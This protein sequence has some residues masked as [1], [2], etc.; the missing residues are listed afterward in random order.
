VINRADPRLIEI[1]LYWR[2]ACEGE[3]K[4]PPAAERVE[5]DRQRRGQACEMGLPHDA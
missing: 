5:Y 4:A 3:I 1:S 2:P